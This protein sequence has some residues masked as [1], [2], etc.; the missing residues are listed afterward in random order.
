MENNKKLV[1]I[2]GGTT[3][4]GS[5]I[6]KVFLSKKWKVIISARNK[7][8]LA[9]KNL[10]NLKFYKMDAR[11]EEDHIRIVELGI[12][13]NKTLDCY[14]NCAG[15][16][17]W[18]P[19][20][21]VDNDFFYKLI[22]TNL[23]GVIWGCKSSYKKLKSGGSIINI[24]SIAS[25]RGSKNN[26]IYCASKFAVNGVTQSLAKEFGKKNIRVNA[27]CPV[28]IL[29]DGLKTAFKSKYSPIGKKN[30][31]KY[32]KD[33]ILNQSA[34]Q[35]IPNKKDVAELCYFLASNNSKFLTGQC[36]NIDGGVLPQ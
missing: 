10:K 18:K 1:I 28:N 7:K 3:G 6:A 8:G 24:S 23:K 19:L 36:I 34:L 35:K 16:S 12:K 27:V 29:T 26:S 11:L 2:T 32:L 9:N 5:S 25:K 14:I 15:I 22:D 4:I 31:E 33:F 13:W 21:K 20:E 17:S 30:I